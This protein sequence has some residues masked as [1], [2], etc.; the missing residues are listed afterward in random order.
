MYLNSKILYCWYIF[1]LLAIILDM[2]TII[3]IQSNQ[4]CWSKDT[5]VIRNNDSWNCIPILHYFLHTV[6]YWCMCGHV[7]FISWRWPNITTVIGIL[8]GF[9]S[10]ETFGWSPWEKNVLFTPL[11]EQ[12]PFFFHYWWQGWGRFICWIN[13]YVSGIRVGQY[14]RNIISQI[15]TYI[16]CFCLHKGHCILKACDCYF[17]SSLS[18]HSPRWILN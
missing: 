9:D 14:D 10:V 17:A 5:E 11:N 15:M 13:N 3:T 12:M 7:F 16:S 8:Y 4:T 18:V 1:I 6:Q 2:L